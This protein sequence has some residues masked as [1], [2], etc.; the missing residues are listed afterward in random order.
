MCIR[1]RACPGQVHAALTVSGLKKGLAG[2][3]GA[4]PSGPASFAGI[5]GLPGLLQLQLQLQFWQIHAALGKRDNSRACPGQAHAA[6][7]VSGL[8]NGLAGHSGAV[9]SG[10]ASF[11]RDRGVAGI[12]AVAVAVAVLADPDCSGEEGEFQGQARP[13]QL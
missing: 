3:S 8:K 1:D 10:P 9:P 12:V 6:L 7:T 13:M 4:V 11:G 5:G 2:H